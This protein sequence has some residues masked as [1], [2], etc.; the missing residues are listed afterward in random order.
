RRPVQ[1]S[2]VQRYL[3]VIKNEMKGGHDFAYAMIAGYTAVV[4]SPGFLYVEEE[5]G[6]LNDTALATRL[7]F[8]LWNSPPDPALLERAARGDLRKPKLLGAESERL[9]N[10]PKSNR[11]VDGF[12]DYWL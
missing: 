4:C 9:L 1:E 6:R 2:E 11:F 8:F 3:A 5:P 7:A 12:L 10:D